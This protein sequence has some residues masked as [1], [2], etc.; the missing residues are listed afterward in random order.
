MEVA[1]GEIGVGWLFL[2]V[3]G[4][5]WLD[6]K[7]SRLWYMQTLRAGPNDLRLRN[8]QAK[9]L[10]GKTV[11]VVGAGSLGAPLILE[12]ARNGCSTIQVI[13]GD[14]VE[15]GNS[16]R[17]PLGA[18]AWGLH[19]ADALKAYLAQHHPSCTLVVHKHLLGG[20]ITDLTVMEAACAEAALVIDA[21]ASHGVTS[22]VAAQCR[23]RS[24]SLVSVMATANPSGVVGGTVAVM[25]PTGG[26]PRCL[27]HAQGAGAVP[28][29]GDDVAEPM[30]QPPGCSDHTFNG[31]SY[32]LEELT[33]Q[34]VRMTVSAMT[35]PRASVVA[36]L[37]Y[38]EVEGIR[39][40]QWR[41]DGFEA[42]QGCDCRRL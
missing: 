14:T 19:K 36:T 31:A 21:S 1:Y 7:G 5:D 37:R 11:A 2:Y 18:P 29:F 42:D 22:W 9:K 15:P 27:E 10:E 33:L 17:W 34:A 39:L 40:P 16:V 3:V 23:K 25:P 26:C 4:K 28:P 41:L 30:L 38:H 20:S 32:D 13:E 35:M 6:R 8:P 24:L 12:L